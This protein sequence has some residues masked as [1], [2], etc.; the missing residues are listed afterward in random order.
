MCK[1]G[2]TFSSDIKALSQL[3]GTTFDMGLIQMPAIAAQ[4]KQ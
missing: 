2:Y 1:A 4:M 3:F